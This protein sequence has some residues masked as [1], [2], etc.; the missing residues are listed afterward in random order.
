VGNQV[1]AE[2]L[3]PLDKQL[4]SLGFHPHEG[5]TMSK[6]RTFEYLLNA[7]EHAAQSSNPALEGYGIKRRKVL[8]YVEQLESLQITMAEVRMTV[9]T[10]ALVRVRHGQ[11]G[12]TPDKAASLRCEQREP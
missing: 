7:M 2:A 8:E 1:L 12:S 4:P 3:F 10:G 5:D 9:P 6:D 11:A